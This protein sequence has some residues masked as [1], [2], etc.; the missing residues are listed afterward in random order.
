MSCV[1][2]PNGST[3][4]WWKFI[5]VALN[6]GPLTLFYFF[7]L[8][9]QINAVSSSLYAVLFYSQAIAPTPY[10]RM[11][12]FAL[13]EH[14]NNR[15]GLITALTAA[16][17]LATPYG[18]WNLK[19]LP[20]FRYPTYLGSGLYSCHLSPHFDNHYLLLN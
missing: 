13:K 14:F 20:Q 15:K 4:N 2:C 10:T 8:F 3:K 19:Y 1:E 18:V 16:K 6:F 7:I 17:V 12:L 5:L 11:V 9:F